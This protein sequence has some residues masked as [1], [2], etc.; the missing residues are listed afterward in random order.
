MNTSAHDT[1]E[2]MLHPPADAL[3]SFGLGGLDE[4]EASVIAEHVSACDACRAVVDAIAGGT[5]AALLRDADGLQSL[6]DGDGTDAP[7]E[8]PTGYKLLEI[9]GEGGMGVVYKAQQLGLGRVVAL[10]QVRAAALAGRDGAARFRREAEAAARLRHPNIVPIYDVGRLDGVPYYAMEF[11]EGGSLAQRLEA[12]P[13]GPTQAARLIEALARAVEHAHQRGVVHRDLKPANVLLGPDLDSPKIS[14]FGLAKRDG[15]GSRT[16]TGTILGTPNY[17]APEQAEGD[18]ARIGPAADIYALGAILYEVLTGRR[19]FS[20][21]SAIETLQLVRQAEPTAPRRIRREVP[22]DLE[23]IAMKCLEKSPA[24]RY[25]SARSLADDLRRFLDGEP[26]GARPVSSPERLAKWARRRPWKAVSAALGLLGAVGL[27]A[28][29]LVHNARLRVEKVRADAQY[30]SARDAIGLMLNRFDDP[31]YVGQPMPMGLRRQLL[32]DALAF[33][34]GAVRDDGPA[35]FSAR[36]DKLRAF[37]EAA[38]FQAMLGRDVDAER[39]LHRALGLVDLLAAERADDPEVQSARVDCL[40]KLGMAVAQD[41]KRTDEAVAYLVEAI[42]KGDRPVESDPAV[43]DRVEALAWC[44]TSLGNVL[45][46][47]GRGAEAEPHYRRAVEIRTALHAAHPAH[48]V[49]QARLADT[50]IN[51]GLIHSDPGHAA[52]AEAEFARAAD[53]LTPVVRDHPEFQPGPLSLAKLYLNWGQLARLVQQTG[54]AC[55]RFESGLGLVAGV[56]RGSPDWPEARQVASRLNGARA[57]VYEEE[58]RFADAAGEWS[59]AVELSDGAERT[60][61]RLCYSCCLARAGRP[62]EAFAEAES[63]AGSGDRGAIDFYN[64]AC[65]ASL[66]AAQAGASGVVA[67]AYASKAMEWLGRARSLGLFRDPGLIDAVDRDTDLAFLRSRRDFQLFRLD[68]AFP[69][70]PLAPGR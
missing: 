69:A 13:L 17:M 49:L 12:G 38:R 10:K 23:T 70:D 4:D 1:P 30:R 42:E 11:V 53:W 29:T 46:S 64:M 55:Q 62:A 19:P 40:T 44:H 32:E 8:P 21:A 41:R 20:A 67:D 18:S 14:D 34:E 60:L 68:A 63:I 45:Q 7:A 51:L 31:K 33:Y 65:V 16:E 52:E 54:R 43:F 36:V 35:D 3:A 66:C 6:A 25:D 27:V 26:I 48:F 50:L 24:R 28:G 39:T 61:F 22:R 2:A 15:D 57:Q 5:F 56:M 37:G 59:R 9:V 47:A 58:G